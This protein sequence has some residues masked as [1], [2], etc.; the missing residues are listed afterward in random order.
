MCV[1][2][3]YVKA[4]TLYHYANLGYIFTCFVVEVG[5]VHHLRVLPVICRPLPERERAE[6][7]CYQPTTS[8][9]PDSNQPL[10][11]YLESSHPADC[12]LAML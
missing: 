8:N 3:L 5:L 12:H 11:P 9:P 6:L 10:L 2:S 7:H 1:F 4:R